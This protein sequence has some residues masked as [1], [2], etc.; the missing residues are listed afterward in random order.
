MDV[1]LCKMAMPEATRGMMQW[2]V[3]LIALTLLDNAGQA[4]LKA[5]FS[6]RSASYPQQLKP[7]SAN[8]RLSGVSIIKYEWLVCSLNFVSI[9]LLP[10]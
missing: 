2:T 10:G 7:W 3:T 5:N 6:K 9:S 1:E 4:C 8:L